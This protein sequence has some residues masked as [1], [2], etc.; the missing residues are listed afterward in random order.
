MAN[1]VEKTGGFSEFSSGCCKMIIEH[2]LLYKRNSEHLN[3][4]RKRGRVKKRE[5]GVSDLKY[6]TGC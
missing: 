6:R 3:S 4:Y 5:V 2:D 1:K